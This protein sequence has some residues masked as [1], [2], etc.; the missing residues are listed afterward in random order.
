MVNWEQRK[1]VGDS[2]ERRVAEELR[3]RGWH[4][5]AWGQGV[6]DEPVRQALRATETFARWTPDLVVARNRT[7]CFVDCKANMTGR[8]SR[9]HAIE[10]AAVRAHLQLVAWNN[11]PVYYVFDSLGVATP[12]DV[13]MAGEPGGTPRVGSGAPYF[14]ISAAYDRSFDSIFGDAKDSA[15]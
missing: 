8:V 13:L 9:R 3:G 7:V 5:N 14:L 15:A 4:V 2:L 6:L 1:R 12:Y 10:R 11:L